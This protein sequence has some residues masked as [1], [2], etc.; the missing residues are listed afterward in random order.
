MGSFSWLH[1]FSTQVYD[2]CDNKEQIKK[3]VPS[4]SSSSYFSFI[5]KEKGKIPGG[6]GACNAHAHI[7]WCGARMLEAV[8]QVEAPVS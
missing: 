1:A 4:V 5:Q 6:A 3:K 8:K 2:L 7:S